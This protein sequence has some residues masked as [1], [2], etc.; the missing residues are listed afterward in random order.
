MEKNKIKHQSYYSSEMPNLSKTCGRNDGNNPLVLR[1]H[2]TVLA[3]YS[4]WI[5]L[6]NK[7]VKDKHK[8][9]HC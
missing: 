7:H 5:N 8:P 6:E 9:K 4:N 3:V 2:I 1:K